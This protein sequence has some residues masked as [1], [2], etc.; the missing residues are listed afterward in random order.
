MAKM[1]SSIPPAFHYTVRAS[2]GNPT[3]WTAGERI[4]G[5]ERFMDSVKGQ[6]TLRGILIG[7][8]GCAIITASSVYIALRMGALP[9][10][11]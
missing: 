6:L 4:Y 7:S 5:K 3:P 2:I 1:T 9:C 10:A 11:L 8:V